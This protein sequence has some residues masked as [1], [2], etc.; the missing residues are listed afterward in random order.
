[1]Y[2]D[3]LIDLLKTSPEVELKKRIEEFLK[4]GCPILKI[5]LGMPRTHG[6]NQVSGRLDRTGEPLQ[7]Q[8]RIRDHSMFEA[9]HRNKIMCSQCAAFNT[10]GEVI[11]GLQGI[12]AEPEC[13]W[14]IILAE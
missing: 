7:K 8:Q 5:R 9:Y 14:P 13:G 6:D 1:M 11:Q 2:Y 10:P 4:F 12:H 3:E